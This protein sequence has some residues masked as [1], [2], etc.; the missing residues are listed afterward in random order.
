MSTKKILKNHTSSTRLEELYD[1]IEKVL[2]PDLISIANIMTIQKDVRIEIDYYSE[3]IS[4]VM[5]EISNN[6]SFYD[7]EAYKNKINYYQ[8]VIKDLQKEQN[9]LQ[10]ALKNLSI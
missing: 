5:N 9:R 7:V 8:L 1:S 10:K 3:R 2:H 4:E 6:A